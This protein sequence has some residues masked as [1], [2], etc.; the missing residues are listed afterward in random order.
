MKMSWDAITNVCVLED[1]T[2]VPS[3]YEVIT[4]TTD[5]T[6][7]DLWKDKKKK[8]RYLAFTRNRSPDGTDNVLA[9]IT[10][11]KEDQL[12]PAGYSCIS[13]T[14][15][16]NEPVLKR[17]S[18]IIRLVNRATTNEAVTD[19]YITSG[20]ARS[21][22]VESTARS[23]DLKDLALYLRYGTVIQTR[24]NNAVNA[25]NLPYQYPARTSSMDATTEQ[26]PPPLPRQSNLTRQ[27]TMRSPE[28]IAHMSGLDD[29]PFE[30]N[31]LL[32][33]MENPSMISVPELTLKSREEVLR[34]YEYDFSTEN[35]VKEQ[36][37]LTS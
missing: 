15:D 4:S 9:D 27:A 8:T 24:V 19:I 28:Q 35:V 10:V 11:V 5:N 7:A 2:R 22:P 29:V 20:K 6:D 34:M 13:H 32:L 16:S 37:A 18:V 3:G 1:K 21:K 23:W 36:W 17:K 14:H 12:T 26:L 30:L 25:A 31:P 33:A